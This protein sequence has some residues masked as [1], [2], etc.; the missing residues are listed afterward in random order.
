VDLF[1]GNTAAGRASCVGCVNLLQ[2]SP[3]CAGYANPEETA[4]FGCKS[5]G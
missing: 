2:D 4:F 1:V 3:A 5:P